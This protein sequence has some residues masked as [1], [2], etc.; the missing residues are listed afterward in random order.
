MRRTDKNAKFNYV[1]DDNVQILEMPYEGDRL[2]M[3][4]LL[5]ESDDLSSLESSLSLEKINDWRSKLKEKRVDVFMPKFTFDTKYF[6]NETLAKMGMPTAFTYDA[7]LSGMDGTQNLSIQKVGGAPASLK[8]LPT[9]QTFP[10]G[11]QYPM[12]IS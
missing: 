11:T 2:S 12:P 3:M 1:E 4:I 6:M 8:S 9:F 10:I 7:D 5:P